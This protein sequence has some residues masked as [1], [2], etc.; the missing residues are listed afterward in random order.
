M[1]ALEHLLGGDG[2]HEA[3]A[4][5]SE[6]DPVAPHAL[7]D[8]I[9]H[10]RKGALHAQLHVPVGTDIPVER[11]EEASHSHD[12]LL[13]RRARLALTMRSWH[14]GRPGPHDSEA[15]VHSSD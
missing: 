9:H 3:A 8:S 2:D 1:M 4:D 14:H 7:M 6:H 12:Q 10:L 13:A 5:H 15:G 11:L